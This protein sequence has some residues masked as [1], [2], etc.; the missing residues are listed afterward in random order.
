MDIVCD[1]GEDL[2]PGIRV[3]GASESL[4]DLRLQ[5]HTVIACGGGDGHVSVSLD[6][7]DSGHE[8]VADCSAILFHGFLE[9]VLQEGPPCVLNVLLFG[10]V[11]ERAKN[12]GRA[13]RRHKYLGFVFSHVFSVSF[14]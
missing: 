10:G 11:D 8:P 12:P 13:R 7:T 5:Q 2:S 3:G 9:A 4:P 14:G 1:L 6:V